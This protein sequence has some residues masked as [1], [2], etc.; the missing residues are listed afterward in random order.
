MSVLEVGRTKTPRKMFGR[1]WEVGKTKKL[2]K[3]FGRDRVATKGLQGKIWASV[4]DNVSDVR[5]KCAGL[6]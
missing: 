5:K 3:M 4:A 1:N 2:R 6:V